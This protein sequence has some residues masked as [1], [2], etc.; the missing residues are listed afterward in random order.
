MRK[1]GLLYRISHLRRN[2]N[3]ILSDMR[4]LG[5]IIITSVYL[6]SVFSYIN[7]EAQNTPKADI[8]PKVVTLPSTPKNADLGHPNALQSPLKI[9]QASELRPYK[10]GAGV[11]QQKLIDWVWNT[12]KD[13]KFIYLIEAESGWRNIR[14]YKIGLNGHYDFG[15]GQ[16]N[17]GFHPEI[18]NDKSFNNP[19]W[20]IKKVYELYK[21]GTRFYGLNRIGIAKRNFEW[22]P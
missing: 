10:I 18:V 16:V 17:S 14:S 7:F 20:Q 9:A 6:L 19:E 13:E 8:L 5:G 3:L 1:G 2:D 15:F 11:D 4:F 22:L 21:G 12:F